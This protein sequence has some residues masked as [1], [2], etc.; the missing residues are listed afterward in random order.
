MGPGSRPS[1]EDDPTLA[2]DGPKDLIII[3]K[4]IE[5]QTKF[6]VCHGSLS[7]APDRCPKCGQARNSVVV[8]VLLPSIATV[9]GRW[10]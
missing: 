7:H 2:Q 9:I 6:T 5:P 8:A 1:F 4:S 10:I 3:G